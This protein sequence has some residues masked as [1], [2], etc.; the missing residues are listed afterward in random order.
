M[1]GLILCLSSYDN[2]GGWTL[3][4]KSRFRFLEGMTCED[5]QN[6]DVIFFPILT[7]SG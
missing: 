2:D 6:T 5:Q 1:L 3:C 4:R 7:Y